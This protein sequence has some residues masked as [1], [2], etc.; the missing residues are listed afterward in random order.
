MSTVASRLSTWIRRPS[1]W[2][3]II[4]WAALVA[5]VAFT[6]GPA[7]T[8]HATF[9]NTG[10]L[11]RYTPWAQTL[12]A[13]GGSTNVYTSDPLDSNAPQ[14][15]M[16]VR[17]AHA[18]VFAAWDPYV[19]GGT[20]LGGV[21]DSGQWSPLSLPWWILPLSYAPG[22][23]KF[24]EIVVIT[25]GMSL[26]LRRWGV[27]RAGWPIAALLYSASGFMVAWSNW[28]QTR[29]A[30]FLPLLFWA[31]DRAAVELRKRDLLSVGGAVSAMLLGGF[32]AIVGYALF[33]GGVFFLVRT[34]VAHRAWLRVLASAG[35]AVGGIVTGVFLSAWQLVP[36]AL[37][38]VS[39][40]D[41]SGRAQRGPNGLGQVPLVTSWVPDISFAQATGAAWGTRN[42]VEEYSFL[43]VAALV[44]V[45]AALLVRP[46]A[47][48]VALPST[49]SAAERDAAALRARRTVGTVWVLAAVLALAVVVVYLGGPL[50]TAVR[51]LPVFNS[52][53]IGRARCVVLFLGAAAAGVGF[54]RLT[55]AEHL[56]AEVTRFRT[57]SPPARAGRIAVVVVVVLVAAGVALLTFRALELVPKQY[58][59]ATKVEVLV[60]GVLGVAAVLAVLVVWATRNRVVRAVAL[61]AVAAMV[62]VPAVTATKPWW[63]LAPASTFYPEAPAIEYLQ[64]HVSD[65]DR[66]TTTG[67]ATLLGAASY[68]HIRSI[69]GHT[70]QTR[71]WKQLMRA[72]DPD[73]YPTA[74]YLTLEPNRMPQLAESGILDRLATR[75]MIADPS[76]PLAGDTE[77]APERTTWTDLTPERS[78]V[79]SAT[80]RG[81]VNGI[82][83]TGPPATTLAPG[84]MR[85]T[86]AVV[87]DD[88]GETLAS[89]KSWVP[90][91]GGPRNVALQGSDIPADTAWHL[92]ITVTGQQSVVPIGTDDDGKAVISVTRPVAADRVSVVHTGDA[93]IY[94]RSNALPRV[95]WASSAVVEP[96]TEGMLRTLADQSLPDDT[97]VLSARPEHRAD[98]DATAKVVLRPSDV[99]STVAR[100]DATGGGWVVVAD[101]LQRDGWTATV[102][103]EPTDL[104]RADSVGAAVW[105]P[106]GQHTVELEYHT[107]G[108][109]EG[110]LLSAVTAA[111]AAATCTVVLLLRRRRRRRAA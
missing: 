66:Y 23:V 27:P 61:G 18:G 11:A 50:L 4:A 102:D 99:N 53:P 71:E 40:V 103:G 39:V 75:Y 77:A 82:T 93:T 14:T 43:G 76:A 46:V 107:P 96:D 101:S 8:G 95:R 3:E 97:V 94:R 37:N 48:D 2:V 59:H 26:L 9:L 74:T 70:F 78:T 73:T 87:A 108:L 92:V 89:T 49:A 35:I 19:A 13:D 51:E 98:P 32:P 7:L 109:R 54:G 33:F 105:V 80:Q 100:V 21:P 85:L 64:D 68:F 57:A 5:F 34:V 29:V 83:F 104:V 86:V 1:A 28:P 56:R 45:A 20:A 12:G 79:E 44:L 110:I 62:V 31:I 22:A 41:F 65:Q 69:T 38:A 88:S 90:G 6:L 10:L 111:V 25:I 17:L 52:N 42:P 15:S 16:L 30:A 47:R 81:P 72:V 67:N 60:V 106:A 91:L 84:G 55:D 36:F 24:L 63:P 58:V